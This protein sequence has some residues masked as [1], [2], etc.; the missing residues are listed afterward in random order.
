TLHPTPYNLH[1]TSFILHPTPYTLHPTPYTLHPT[2]YTLHSN[3]QTTHQTFV[4]HGVLDDGKVEIECVEIGCSAVFR[5]AHEAATGLFIKPS[6]RGSE[7]SWS[8][9]SMK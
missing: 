8:R 2:P 5:S 3:P 4:G 9:N 1:P 7:G 6:F